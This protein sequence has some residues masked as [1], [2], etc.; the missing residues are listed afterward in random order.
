MKKGI[1]I[2]AMGGPRYWGEARNNI[3][4]IWRLWPKAPIT[5]I[6]EDRK[7]GGPRVVHRDKPEGA[8]PG[9]AEVIQ[10]ED[11]GRGFKNQTAY[12]SATPY[13]LTVHLDCDAVP[14][15][16]IFW[17][18]YHLLTRFDFVAAHAAARNP[19][20]QQ[21]PKIP[22]AFGQWN[23]GVM[24]YNRNLI[25]IFQEWDRRQ[26]GGGNPQGPLARLIWENPEIRTYTLHPEW[27][28]R[29]GLVHV[30][31]PGMVICGHHHTVPTLIRPDGSLKEDE[32][33]TW[34]WWRTIQ[35][36]NLEGRIGPA[37]KE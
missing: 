6:S 9:M 33:R 15:K 8:P 13:D 2:I 11:L 10:V 31:H 36:L 17:Q 4:S 30:H 20:R 18:P 28:Y 12:M 3:L 29:G 32:F 14:L 26:R 34:F 23:C 16:K 5:I 24:F 19:E 37:T 21:G 1:L 7:F 27:N 35:K 25:P 22:G